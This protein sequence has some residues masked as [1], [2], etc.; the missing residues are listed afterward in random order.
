M[1][2]STAEFIS[3]DV[4]GGSGSIP[5]VSDMIAFKMA[6]QIMDRLNCCGIDGEIVKARLADNL[7]VEEV[8]LRFAITRESIYW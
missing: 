1:L 6:R 2:K 8:A 4:A 7:S 5:Y 3:A